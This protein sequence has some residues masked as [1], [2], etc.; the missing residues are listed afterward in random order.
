[1][2]KHLI[3][4]YQC[5]VQDIRSIDHCLLNRV[6]VKSIRNRNSQSSLEGNGWECQSCTD[7]PW[8]LSQPFLLLSLYPGHHNLQPLCLCLFSEEEKERRIL[9]T[10]TTG[11][12]N[13]PLLLLLLIPAICHGRKW[14][15]ACCHSS[16]DVCSGEMVVTREG[17]GLL[18]YLLL[19]IHNLYYK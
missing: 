11:A 10:E 15:A 9:K 12:H 8:P 2:L 18:R 13:H 17:G 19:S 6:A 14:W 16:S 3:S 7:H 5:K 1:M 4:Q